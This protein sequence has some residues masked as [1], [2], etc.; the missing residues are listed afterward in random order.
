M[1]RSPRIV[2]PSDAVAAIRHL[3]IYGAVLDSPTWWS[4]RH[5]HFGLRYN[6][7]MSRRRKPN[8]YRRQPSMVSRRVGGK[9][10]PR[11]PAGYAGPVP[12]VKSPEQRDLPASVM[13]CREARHSITNELI[14]AMNCETFPWVDCDGDFAPSMAATLQAME[15]VSSNPVE[16][17]R[18]SWL[19]AAERA[20]EDGFTFEVPPVSALSDARELQPAVHV[21]CHHQA[22]S[23]HSCNST[24]VLVS[25]EPALEGLRLT[26][27]MPEANLAEACA[28]RRRWIL[29]SKLP[30]LC[31]EGRFVEDAVAGIPDD[32]TLNVFDD[33]ASIEL[34]CE[35]EE[36]YE[37][38][39]QSIMGEW[40]PRLSTLAGR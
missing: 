16:H 13:E 8:S 9:P 34:R 11:A 38:G 29:G 21:L 28:H 33:G 4:P 27:L 7:G 10:A 40:E 6:Q 14:A 37:A 23:A 24:F 2:P 31:A 3:A 17:F 15:I 19:H 26:G 5:G 35:H 12:V 18:R 25:G 32:L 22:C 39:M 20:A 1:V 36:C 30:E